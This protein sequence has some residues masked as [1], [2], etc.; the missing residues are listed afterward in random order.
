M[1]ETFSFNTES[2]DKVK[3]ALSKYPEDRKQSAVMA[4]LDIAQRQNGGWL[5][6]VSYTHLTLPTKA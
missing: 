3:F 6:T 2:L 4:L 1:T 5:S